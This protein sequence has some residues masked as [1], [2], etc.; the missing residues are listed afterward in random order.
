MGT[1]GFVA[2]CNQYTFGDLVLVEAPGL[3]DRVLGTSLYLWKQCL[4]QVS[5]HVG[6]YSHGIA[7]WLLI[8]T[9][10]WFTIFQFWVPTDPCMR[11]KLTTL[12]FPEMW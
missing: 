9:K 10:V 12:L 4:T 2:M 5:R 8:G 7:A 1:L 6:N 11:M 3:Q